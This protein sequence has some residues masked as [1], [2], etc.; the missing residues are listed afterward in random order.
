MKCS[1][2]HISQEM[3][4]LKGRHQYHNVYTSQFERNTLLNIYQQHM[5]SELGGI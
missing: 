1:Q 3:E 5:Y 2:L 4:K